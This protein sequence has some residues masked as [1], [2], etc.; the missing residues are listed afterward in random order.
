[1]DTVQRVVEPLSL[2]SAVFEAP[3]IVRCV[4]WSYFL[5]MVRNRMQGST[6]LAA[7]SGYDTDHVGVRSHDNSG[8]SC[9]NAPPFAVSDYAGDKI[10]PSVEVEP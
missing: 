9:R 8:V 3:E 4:P 5:T 10:D 1:M 6:V 7:V 2:V